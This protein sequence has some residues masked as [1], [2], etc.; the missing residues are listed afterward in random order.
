MKLYNVTFNLMNDSNL[1]MPCVPFT[2]GPGEDRE[3]KRIC[4]ADSIESKYVNKT[5]GCIIQL[6]YFMKIFPFYIY[7]LYK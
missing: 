6:F 5:V 1:L 2:A 3:I 4:L 7:N